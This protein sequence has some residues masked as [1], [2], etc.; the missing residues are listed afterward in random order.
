MK[1]AKFN[2]K[3]L[4]MLVLPAILTAF[5]VCGQPQ[6]SEERTHLA[7]SLRTSL[8]TVHTAPDSLPILYDIFDLTPLTERLPVAEEL[9]GVTRR[10][11]NDAASLDVLRHMATLANGMNDET[12]AQRTLD[13]ARK[14][15]PS[16]DRKQTEVY[17]SACIAGAHQ[18][19]SE[20]DRDNY[21][22]HLIEKFT[23]SANSVDPYQRAA[24]LFTLIQALSG[25][26][27][28]VIVEE[29]VGDLGSLLSTLPKM[30]SNYLQIKLNSM[31]AQVYWSNDEPEKSVTA[32]RRLLDSM[33]KMQ[34]YYNARERR[35]INFDEQRYH[36]IR[37]MM[38]SYEVL[39]Q[40]E[41]LKLDSLAREIAKRNPYIKEDYER[42]P[43]VKIG[44]LVKE[45][46][47]E[48]ALPMVRMMIAN[49]SALDERRH[50]QRQLIRVAG[51]AG[52]SIAKRDAEAENSYLLED[53]IAHKSGERLR[54]LQILYDVSTLRR[55]TAEQK[56]AQQNARATE[57][58]IVGVI[59]GLLLMVFA[60]L[61]FRFHALSKKLK[62]ANE[63][64]QQERASMME[65]QQN[66][67]AARDKA[68]QAETEKSQLIT[69][70]GHEVMVPLN[71]ITEYTRM[72]IDNLP[73]EKKEYMRKF[74]DV[75]DGNAKILQS[76]AV[77]V[78]EFSLMDAH[79]FA[80]N[81]VPVDANV[82][83][84]LAVDSIMPLVQPGVKVSIEPDAGESAMITTDSRRVESALMSLLSNA[85]KFT[86][87]GSI[88]VSV[89]INRE[90]ETATYAVADTGIGIPADKADQ[91]F[92]R[93]E[94][95]NP[96]RQGT[97]LGLP[98][99][100]MIAKALHGTVRLDTTYPGPGSRFL[101][102]IPIA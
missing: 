35:Y 46:N 25:E 49:A 70:V 89:A 81:R 20:T 86:D 54:E 43:A 66:L 32:D 1:S 44:K 68:R 63:V 71:A 96:E 62:S 10:A 24:L 90:A 85:A 61:Y 80:V 84:R 77:D 38:R 56:L 7:D 97:G 64:M 73:E 60:L 12:L 30:Q 3:S 2:M 26:D 95:L 101:F 88:T 31:A 41:A 102:T 83:A 98:N 78:Q 76:I 52:D 37:R 92:E 23:A 36:S 18:F 91:I 100:V 74:A 75:I 58:T 39:S 42:N 16:E 69:Y 40:E 79:K 53:Y 50:L 9:L 59:L 87:N 14:L 6:T 65:T 4:R 22:R 57:I 15:S 19:R 93:F 29:Y 45:G 21:L 82:L 17:I 11:G 67:I 48:E 55:Q 99:C 33:D 72:I 28:G 51:L 47:Y 8:A 13:E 94:R 34:Q 5:G 27:Q